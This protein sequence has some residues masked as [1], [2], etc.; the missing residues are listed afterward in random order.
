M[1]TARR[2]G[3]NVAIGATAAL[4]SVTLLAACSSDDDQ[5]AAAPTVTVTETVSTTAEPTASASASASPTGTENSETPECGRNDVAAKVVDGDAGAGQRRASLV[6]TNRSEEPCT[7]TGYPG[8]QL[9][10]ATGAKVPT[11]VVR[12]GSPAPRTVTLT[13]GK[14]ASAA[15]TWGVIPTGSDSED[16]P[17][18]PAASTL[19]VIPPDAR[20]AVTTPWTLGPVCNKGKITVNAF[21]AGNG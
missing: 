4:V 1:R 9:T 7:V 11:T 16:G 15:L 21:V 19:R 13:P 14:P 12:A 2:A 17:C 20:D 3:R 5:P 10:T 6:L 18:Q 8:L